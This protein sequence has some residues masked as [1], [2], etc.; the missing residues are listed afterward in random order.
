MNNQNIYD[1][2]TLYSQ[3]KLIPF[4]GAGLSVPFK[5]P[6]WSNL[7]IELS[8]S[9]DASFLN[10]IKF[11]VNNGDYW[12][13][14]ELLMRYGNFDERQ[15]QEMI[16][17][18]I[19]INQS[20][21]INDEEHNYSD[22]GKLDFK[23]IL[24]TNYDQWI[25]KFLKGDSTYP[26]PQNLNQAS[27]SSYDLVLDQLRKQIFHLH[28]NISDIDS[29]VITKKKYKQI[30]S[31]EKY[32]RFFSEFYANFVFLFMGFSF[33][34]KYIKQLI[35]DYKGTFQARHFILLDKPSGKVIRNLK[36]KYRLEVI[37]YDSTNSS[38][39]KEIRKILN[40][41]SDTKLFLIEK[42]EDL[43]KQLI[44]EKSGEQSLMANHQTSFLNASNTCDSKNVK[45][46]LL[47]LYAHLAEQGID[48]IKSK[49]MIRELKENYDV[50]LAYG[51][52]NDNIYKNID[53]ISLRVQ[54]ISEKEF[55][56]SNFNILIIEN[57]LG[58]FEDNNL[59]TEKFRAELIKS[60]IHSGG[61]CIYLLSD[62]IHQYG[63]TKYNEF[64]QQ[65]GIPLIKQAK[66][67]DEFP[68]IHLV[69]E[70][71]LSKYLMYGW[72]E[73][74]AIDYPKKY[75]IKVDDFYYP[76]VSP[77]IL[78]IF[79]NINQLVVNATLQVDTRLG[80]V[81][82]AANKSTKILAT[83]DLM[84]D[85]EIGHFIGTY[86]EVGY[87]IG[88]LIGAN[89]CEDQILFMHKSDSVKFIKNTIE[90]FLEEIKLRKSLM[91]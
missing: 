10:A 50:K 76:L 40:E 7:I 61:I 54:L 33:D 64:L 65:A 82:L 14:I 26:Y 2:K 69:D 66:S 63:I 71:N 23:F 91:S 32:K 20:E 88:I 9:I 73:K 49:T 68:L 45:P 1:L 52:T 3:N 77:N 38:H 39:A 59:S 30:Y 89:I 31:Q 44:N 86:N 51:I 4:I 80:N 47:Y 11:E 90:F 72:D 67:I 46:K 70:S 22:I 12:K 18:L 78:P 17:N 84:W 87:G 27:L 6:N 21:C 83:G 34:D 29:L 15:I 60:F 8:S 48:H 5:I 41:L 13:A 55:K 24:T 81:L 62:N 16:V 43:N 85:G 57:R 36:E 28:G 25:Y 79:E 19:R 75:K 56:T 53:N 37:S 58:Q 42:K 74:F 35:K